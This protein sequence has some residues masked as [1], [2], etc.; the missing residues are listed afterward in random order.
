M[1]TANEEEK[2]NEIPAEIK[3]QLDEQ[4]ETINN[5]VSELKEVRSKKQEAEEAAQ[6][7]L[8]DTPK[9][10]KS[11]DISTAL[12]AELD[13]RAKQDTEINKRTAEVE[14]RNSISEFSPDNDPGDIKYNMF[15]KEIAKF[16]F[17]GLTTKEEINA[18]YQEV[19]DF[20]NRKKEGSDSKINQYAS[21]SKTGYTRSDD[22]SMTGLSK[23][24]IDL[25]TTK[26]WSKDKYLTLK[27]KQPGFI[28]QLL[29]S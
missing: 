9:E 4:K 21:T 25:I 13:K 22:T 16:N 10:D 1:S 12:Q 18:R 2:Q 29:R 8:N 14:F 19:Y 24:E 26:G 7:L 5:L 15:K 27:S 20:V 11:I 3:A 17:D 28:Q 6:A 23:T